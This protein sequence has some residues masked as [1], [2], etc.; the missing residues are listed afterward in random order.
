MVLSVTKALAITL[1]L[2]FFLIDAVVLLILWL[3]GLATILAVRVGPETTT[4]A[5]LLL[6]LF[7]IR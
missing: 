4:L 7:W 1:A 3:G 6:W 5:I 2:V